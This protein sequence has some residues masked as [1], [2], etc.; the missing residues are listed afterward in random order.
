M[1]LTRVT[2]SYLQETAKQLYKEEREDDRAVLVA[3]ET[4]RDN[5]NEGRKVVKEHLRSTKKLA[6]R[7][8]ELSTLRKAKARRKCP[9]TPS[10]ATKHKIVSVPWSSSKRRKP[11]SSPPST[12]VRGFEKPPE[13]SYRWTKCYLPS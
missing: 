13:H 8:I 12:P 1:L 2:N 4:K 6:D 7:I 9:T 5:A 10:S 11:R 3:A